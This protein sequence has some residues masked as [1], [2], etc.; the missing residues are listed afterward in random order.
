M[1]LP[2]SLSSDPAI[3][4]SSPAPQ[5]PQFGSDMGWEQVV[6]L[7]HG[8]PHPLPARMLL[9]LCC[10]LRNH[11]RIAS[12]LK[13][14]LLSRWVKQREMRRCYFLAHSAWLRT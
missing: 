9:S 3:L 2:L 12:L 8:G 13:Q 1:H 14:P 7:A 4:P 11:L 6:A 10:L 5:D